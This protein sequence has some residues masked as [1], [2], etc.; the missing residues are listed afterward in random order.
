MSVSSEQVMDQLQSLESQW[1]EFQKQEASYT[2]KAHTATPTSGRG[3]QRAKEDR[4]R[5]ATP[6]SRSALQAT[7]NLLPAA[8]RSDLD[9]QI[10]AAQVQDQPGK[11]VPGQV[12]KRFS[13]RLLHDVEHARRTFLE[14][15]QQ[16]QL[17]SEKLRNESSQALRDKSVTFKQITESRREL[18]DLRSVIDA[19]KTD[20]QRTERRKDVLDA[21]VKKSEESLDDLKK[22]VDDQTQKLSS[23][24]ETM[25]QEMQQHKQ[26]VESRERQLQEWEL[27]LAKRE[28]RSKFWEEKLDHAG[29]LNIKCKERSAD[30]DRRER[31]LDSKAFEA[32]RNIQE[33][34]RRREDLIRECELY[35]KHA[36]ELRSNV[37]SLEHKKQECEERI[38]KCEVS[39][40][41]ATRACKR[42][43]DE[44]ANAHAES[45]HKLM[46]KKQSLALLDDEIGV[47]DD[48]LAGI[49]EEV[50]QAKSKLEV[51]GSE[52]SEKTE[53]M[54]QLKRDE[55]KAERRLQQ[56]QEAT[57][58]AQ[59]ADAL[60]ADEK[61]EFRASCDEW[62]QQ[63]R[64]RE[65]EIQERA[66]E[67]AKQ[68]KDLKSRVAKVARYEA[69]YER[70]YGELDE[71][72]SR[73]EEM[74]DSN[75]KETKELQQKASDLLVH[76]QH[77]HEW[78][79]KLETETVVEL[80]E[81]SNKLSEW[82]AKLSQ[83]EELLKVSLMEL[84]QRQ[85][86]MQT[87]V[88]D[89][90]AK[91]EK[92]E[93]ASQVLQEKRGEI[94][95]KWNVVSRKEI[96][97]E[98]QTQ[99]LPDLSTELDQKSTV[100][101]QYQ[102]E[103]SEKQKEITE[104]M[105]EIAQT[106]ISLQKESLQVSTLRE[107]LEQKL[108]EARAQKAEA[109]ASKE[110][111]DEKAKA[112]EAQL[113]KAEATLEAAAAWEEHKKQV[114]ETWKTEMEQME[115]DKRNA[116]K[117]VLQASQ[118]TNALIASRESLKSIE[119]ALQQR[120]LQL[121]FTW[122]QMKAQSVETFQASTEPLTV[123]DSVLSEI[124]TMSLPMSN[125]H[126]P[127]DLQN[128]EDTGLYDFAMNIYHHWS[129]LITQETK[130]QKWSHALQVEAAKVEKRAKT[131]SME[132]K[133]V[134][135]QVMQVAERMAEADKFE[136]DLRPGRK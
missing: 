136:A 35:E 47:R 1:L 103:I 132:G 50:A 31:D 118:Q 114:E 88:E 29:Q 20:V 48:K 52:I 6:S 36:M 127:P 108:K 87:R 131:L 23:A 123:E 43:M 112:A 128:L 34:L 125:F 105:D 81:K 44:A 120:E 109:H 65:Y 89:Y 42:K 45:D 19:I 86:E 106:R 49:E 39:I 26:A 2:A 17:E 116:E 75:N 102:D 91:A 110:A 10:A 113:A 3:S 133:D 83:K 62:E 77:L 59:E 96:E 72:L 22:R 76:E 67:I 94:E 124:M 84:D 97:I 55:D 135:E 24:R 32:E 71:R 51:L 134:A 79:Q 111:S 126:N 122:R 33:L 54:T 5:E 82:E 30:L 119:Q 27:S 69:E 100:L 107:K 64:K 8:P 78:K 74:E 12:L 98:S 38:S 61:K 53:Q 85:H 104:S 70:A 101:E 21:D 18:Q 56:T 11:A 41:D 58:K 117:V 46:R 80:Q 92:F 95:R 40:L 90:N 14:E 129:Q 7:T 37:E 57:V 60:I 25:T 63:V 73:L 13:Q 28:E 130:L 15:N 9:A 4:E 115:R 121:Q 93:K 66:S 99:R 68:D 16:L